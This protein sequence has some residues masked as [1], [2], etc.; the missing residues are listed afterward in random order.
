[1]YQKGY[2][3]DSSRNYNIEISPWPSWVQSPHKIASSRH[4]PIPSFYISWPSH[5]VFNLVI[6]VLLVICIWIFNSLLKMPTTPKNSSLQRKCRSYL[7]LTR[8]LFIWKVPLRYVIVLQF[9]CSGN[10]N[11]LWIRCPFVSSSL[12][13]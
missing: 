1:M 13:E 10:M 3:L 8:T 7:I 11:N 4:W 6:F 9:S 5:I 12:Y 2:S